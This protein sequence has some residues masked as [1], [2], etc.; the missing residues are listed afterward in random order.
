MFDIDERGKT[1]VLLSLGYDRECKRGFPGR[2]RAK[3]LDN[4]P[5]WKSANAKSAI[6]QNVAGG[7]DVDI[8]NLFVPKAHDRAV[9]IILCNLLNRKVEVFISR[10]S[11]FVSASSLFSF[12]G[13]IQ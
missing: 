5:S 10:D 6:D 8:D 4:P 9:T 12:R 3:H 2:L 7:D 11:E 13:H 1:A